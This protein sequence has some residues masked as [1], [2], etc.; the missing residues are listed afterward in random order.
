[1]H[2][3]F[4]SDFFNFEFLRLLSM[5]PSGGCEIAEAL[6]AVSHIK[7]GDPETWSK[8]WESCST[9]AEGLAKEAILTG[10]KVTARGAYLRA[11]NY[12]RAA[13]FMWNESVG[14]P[15]PR[16][17]PLAERYVSLFQ[18]GV[19]LLDEA[20]AK[21][22]EIPY[23]GV[24][25]LPAIL[26]LPKSQ[27][28]LSGKVPIIINVN[29]G[30]SVQEEL[31]FVSPGTGAKLGYAMLT[32]DGPGQGMALRRDNL[33]MRA[34][35]EFV[36]TKVLD[37]LERY[38]DENKELGLD[39]D[40]IGVLGATIGGYNALRAAGDPRIK[41]CVSIDG[42]YDLWDL[43]TMRIPRW[44]LNGWESGWISASFVNTLVGILARF[45][46]QFKWEL[47]HMMWSLGHDT[48]AKALLALKDF[49][50]NTKSGG[51]YLGN[52]RCPTLVSGAAGTIY[53]RP[54]LSTTR[55]FQ[56][57]TEL[58]EKQKVCWLA[59]EP[60]D[61]GL[62]AKIGAFAV[63]NMRTFAFF[64]KHLKVARKVL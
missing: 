24:K 1:M 28:R 26:Y 56:E 51:S 13:Q 55:I 44:F 12:A 17:L 62:T 31:F 16:L 19:Q 20:D 52:I 33:K 5:A 49:T 18:K 6:A 60:Q 3:F 11:A 32:F 4:T 63:S 48:P 15:E 57:L 43:A 14:N 22:L 25:S 64:D 58:G 47:G 53:F 38:C 9:H 7:D 23:D 59:K 30:D 8:Q 50:F 27:F 2:R 42:P 29:G 10:D 40:K 61:G 45:N 46:F 34:D 41:A 39:L 35:F 37:F 36:T 21:F 54:E